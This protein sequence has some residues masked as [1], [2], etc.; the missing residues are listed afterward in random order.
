[1]DLVRL[2]DKGNCALYKKV[3]STQISRGSVYTLEIT[4]LWKLKPYNSGQGSVVSFPLVS[5]LDIIWPAVHY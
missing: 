4:K 3:P 1:M 2:E 5:L